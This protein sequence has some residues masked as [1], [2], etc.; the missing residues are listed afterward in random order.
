MAVFRTVEECIELA[1]KDVP[2]NTGF[3]YYFSLEETDFD[4]FDL[5]GDT[6][7]QLA[8][9]RENGNWMV[10]LAHDNAEPFDEFT[11]RI[12]GAYLAPPQEGEKE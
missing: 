9:C 11:S 1:K 3:S 8:Q 4:E 5:N 2:C 7:A 12:C 10:E 6:D